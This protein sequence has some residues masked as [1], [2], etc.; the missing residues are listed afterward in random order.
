[1]G[2]TLKWSE[3]NEA[4]TVA[5]GGSIKPLIQFASQDRFCRCCINIKPEWKL[6][7]IGD[8]ISVSIRRNSM[9]HARTSIWKTI[10]GSIGLTFLVALPLYAQEHPEH[11]TEQPKE[12]PPKVQE[13]AEQTKQVPT[14]SMTELSRAIKAFVAQD[15]KLKGGLFLVWDS[16]ANKSLELTL[17]KVHEE[18][19]A[20]LG[21]GV[22]FA[23]ADFQASDGIIYDLDMFMRQGDKGLE[24]TEISVHKEN[25][26]ARYGW[27]EQ[28]GIW[29]KK[30]DKN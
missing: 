18:R 1:M 9:M 13:K 5:T 17:D 3:A 24:M 10:V 11:P 30:A 27:V 23:C 4:T 26:E 15:S 6:M 22:Y 20:S 8:E 2:T 21:G 12:Q 7:F 19:L 14:V 28:D 25:G 16:K 29:T